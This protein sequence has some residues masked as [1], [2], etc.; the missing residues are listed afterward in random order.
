VS[1]DDFAQMIEDLQAERAVIE[2]A[3][4]NGDVPPALVSYVETH[5]TGTSLGDPIEVQ[6]L[7]AVLSRGRPAGLRFQIGSVKTNLGHTESAAGVAGLMKATPAQDT[8]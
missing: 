5:G 1:S 4:A 8:P 7:A 6:A 3:L 2:A